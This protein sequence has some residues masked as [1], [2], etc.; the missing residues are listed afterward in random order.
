VDG[1]EIDRAA[2]A[3][4]R[5]A[6]AHGTEF[7]RSDAMAQ[8]AASA[9]RSRLSD[10]RAV[11]EDQNEVAGLRALAALHIGRIGT[12]ESLDTLIENSRTQTGGILA[13]IVDV[14]GRIGDRRALAAVQ[15]VVKRTNPPLA[16]RAL[17][18]ANL[19]V[20]RLG[21]TGE[22]LPTWGRISYLDASEAQLVEF[23]IR[24]ADPSEIGHVLSR[25]TS[26]Y[27][28]ALVERPAYEISCDRRKDFLVLTRESVRRDA[29]KQWA[30]VPAV[31]GVV[32]TRDVETGSYAVTAIV[33]T[34]PADRDQIEMRGYRP[35]GH[36]LLGATGQLRRDRLHFRLLGV[37]RSAARQFDIIG[38]FEPPALAIASARAA[39]VVHP[40]LR[41]IEG[42]GPGS[43]APDGPL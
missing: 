5:R 3:R 20:H 21:L 25:L 15:D 36:A 31:F 39:P 32:C 1:G 17:F 8:L 42:L 38:T 29:L 24:A 37:A 18:A 11:L 40:K 9:H 19:I 2:I 12:P 28:I 33:L 10:L 23:T 35:N 41:A 13:R 14:L 30:H 43:E 26:R 27:D 16:T 4:L 7:E 6:I 22:G 34:A